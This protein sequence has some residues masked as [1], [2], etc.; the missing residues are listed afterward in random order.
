MFVLV[1]STPFWMMSLL[2]IFL[3]RE[4]EKL[5]KHYGTYVTKY[6]LNQ[7]EVASVS[8][9]KKQLKKVDKEII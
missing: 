4:C 7:S 5:E 9:M 2:Y 1:S 8:A 3:V 6:I